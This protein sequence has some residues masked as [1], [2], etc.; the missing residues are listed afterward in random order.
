[1]HKYRDLKVWQRAMALTVAKYAETQ[2]W[3][4]T[5]KFGL[6]SQTRRAST[7]IALNIAEGA[8]NQSNKEFIRF[9]QFAL[10]STY[11]TMTA[12]EIAQGLNFLSDKRA[13]PLLQESDEIAAM[14]VGLMKT[15][16]WRRENQ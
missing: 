15:L 5:E 6:I 16:G 9:L 4:E 10:R 14:L 3:P 1:M 13:N 2:Q 12:I 8:G 7:S 11:E